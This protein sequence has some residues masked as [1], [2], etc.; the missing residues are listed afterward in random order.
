M[1]KTTVLIADDHELMRES[2]VVL[3]GREPGLEIAGVATDGRTA[4]AMGRSLQP[5]VAFLDVNL[6]LING[7]QV[8]RQIR[9]DSPRTGIIMLSAHDR[10]EYLKEFLREGSSGK[11]FLLKNTIRSAKDLTRS[12]EDVLAG[13]TVLDPAMVTRLT[14]DDSVRVSGALKSLSPRELQVLGLMA[15]AHSNKSIATTLFI[16]PRTVEHHISSILAKLGFTGSGDR[17]GRVFAILT[18]L[19]ASGQLPTFSP[20]LEQPTQALQNNRIAA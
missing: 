8:A 10:G 5:R 7:L 12:I 4:I 19:E 3:L 13:R 16:Q 11:A 18:F 2:L 15:R 6:P 20:G 17:H 14:S 1:Q 9:L